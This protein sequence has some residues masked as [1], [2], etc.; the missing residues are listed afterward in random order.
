MARHFDISDE[1]IHFTGGGG[2]CMDD[3]FAS[4]RAIVRERRLIASSGRIRG[5]YRCVSVTDAPIAAFGPPWASRFPFNRYSQFGMMFDRNWIYERG[6]RPVIH[7]P[8]SDFH[9]LPD[10]LRWRHVRHEPTA[11]HVVDWTWEREWRVPCEELAFTPAEAVIVVPNEQWANRL[12]RVHD[13]GQDMIV[14][15]YAGA[16]DREIAEMWREKFPWRVFSLG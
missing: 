5:G 6:G 1:L 13:G 14:E 4:L 11:E 3:A 16:I 7:Q 15:L 12:R 10:D 2:E 9:L 8:G